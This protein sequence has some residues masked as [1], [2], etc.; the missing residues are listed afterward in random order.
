MTPL[1]SRQA[2]ISSMT[3]K[4]PKSEMDFDLKPGA[5]FSRSRSMASDEAASSDVSEPLVSV[6]AKPETRSYRGPAPVALQNHPLQDAV[7]LETSLK[8]STVQQV[9]E[10]QPV[11]SPLPPPPE[12]KVVCPSLEYS[13]INQTR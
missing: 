13:A 11:I 8:A 12:E 2:S 5:K 4:K 1:R 10:Q 9:R 6:G 7:K 3:G